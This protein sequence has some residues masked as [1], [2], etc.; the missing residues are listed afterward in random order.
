MYGV[1]VRLYS[2]LRPL[3]LIILFL[4]PPQSKMFTRSR[5]GMRK[6]P[7]N[8]HLNVSETASYAGALDYV[9]HYFTQIESHARVAPAY[10]RSILG[11]D[12]ISQ[13][14]EA[15]HLKR[16]HLALFGT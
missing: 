11:M 8:L 9:E 5:K 4:L 13:T 14:H 10:D 3:A 16:A 12:N 6:M 7:S 15:H 1:S 2:A